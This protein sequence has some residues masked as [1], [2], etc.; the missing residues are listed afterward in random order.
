MN[1]QI[2]TRSVLPTIAVPTL[3][4]HRTGDRD[5][6]VEE[7]RWIADQIPGSRFIELPGDDHLPW[8]GDTDELLDEVETFLTGERRRPDPQRWLATVLFTDIVDST[9]QAAALGDRQWND[10]LERHHAVVRRELDRYGGTE[11]DTA[12]DGFFATFDGPARAVRCAA[13]IVDAVRELGL[14]V[15]AGVHTG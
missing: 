11:V 7:E 3:L 15:R 5:V 12:G 14:E 6:S 2:D 9:A 4:L 1:S 8:L 13:A 10:L